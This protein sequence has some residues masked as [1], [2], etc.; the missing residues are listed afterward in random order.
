MASAASTEG[1]VRVEVGGILS[2]GLPIF[3]RTLSL[4][5]SSPVKLWLLLFLSTELAG[6]EHGLSARV[7]CVGDRSGSLKRQ[8]HGV[9]LSSKYAHVWSAGYTK[10]ISNPQA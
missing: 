9:T 1:D 7:L 6:R 5:D 3:F 2:L 8:Q 4:S 10:P